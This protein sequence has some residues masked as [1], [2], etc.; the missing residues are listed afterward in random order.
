[1][2]KVAAILFQ[3]AIGKKP[4]AMRKLIF[5]I[6]ELFFLASFPATLS[7]KGH[8]CMYNV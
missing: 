3:F 8:L 6:A 1:M 7:I 5:E 4:N 2:N